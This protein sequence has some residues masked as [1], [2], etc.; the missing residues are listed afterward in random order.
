M[1]AVRSSRVYN[2]AAISVANSLEN[3]RSKHIAVK[4]HHIRDHVASKL[5]L[6]KYCKSDDNYSDWFTKILAAPKFLRDVK[7]LGVRGVNI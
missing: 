5:I 3:K 6:L 4:H 7:R 2:K 1:T